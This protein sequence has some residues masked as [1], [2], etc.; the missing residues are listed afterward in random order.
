MRELVHLLMK[1]SQLQVLQKS[2]LKGSS[3]FH[4]FSILDANSINTSKLELA[5]HKQWFQGLP[6][7]GQH[8]ERSDG[9]LF[10]TNS[11]CRIK[12]PPALLS[13]FQELRIQS[14]QKPQKLTEVHCSC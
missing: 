8:A 2:K 3:R 9:R 7:S 11:L 10:G 5:I 1:N 6:C 13:S 4:D 14:R 12:H